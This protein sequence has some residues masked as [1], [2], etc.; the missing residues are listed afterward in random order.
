MGCHCLLRAN[1]PNTK[2]L[3]MIFLTLNHS[4]ISTENYYLMSF[5]PQGTIRFCPVLFCIFSISISK[6][7]CCSGAKSC[8]NLCNPMDSSM[9][10][11]S[12]SSVISQ[13]FLK[14]MSIVSMMPANHFIL[15][16]P[17]LLLPSVFPRIRVFSNELALQIT[18]PK[19]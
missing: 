5:F 19:Y 17:I 16:H 18:W 1:F 15:C 6:G 14:F 11:S 13:S 7:C 9:L 10:G 3:G 2:L 8:L 12:L 4:Y